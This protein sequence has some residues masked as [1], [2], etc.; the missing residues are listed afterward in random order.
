MRLKLAT[1]VGQKRAQLVFHATQ[2]PS[3]KA[4]AGGHAVDRNV[5]AFTRVEPTPSKEPF[6]TRNNVTPLDLDTDVST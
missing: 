1:P 6:L 3:S 4:R 2:F 5:S